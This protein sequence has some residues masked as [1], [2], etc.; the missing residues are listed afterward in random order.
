MPQLPQQEIAFLFQDKP[1]TREEIKDLIQNDPQY[2]KYSLMEWVALAKENMKKLGDI[3]ITNLESSERQEFMTSLS[4]L[5]FAEDLSTTLYAADGVTSLMTPFI[6][7]FNESQ[8][9][10]LLAAIEAI[11][12]N[13]EKFVEK[14]KERNHIKFKQ[15]VLAIKPIADYFSQFTFDMRNHHSGKYELTLQKNVKL[16]NGKDIFANKTANEETAQIFLF[17]FFENFDKALKLAKLDEN[18]KVINRTQVIKNIFVS[19]L[20]VGCHL[21]NHNSAALNHETML[22]QE[23]TDEHC[24]SYKKG[25][26]NKYI[27]SEITTNGKLIF[28]NSAFS[29]AKEDLKHTVRKHLYDKNMDNSINYLEGQKNFTQALAELFNVGYV[30][31]GNHG[32]SIIPIKDGFNITY[33]DSKQQSLIDLSLNL[34]GV[35]VLDWDTAVKLAGGVE[36]LQEKLANTKHKVIDTPAGTYQ[37]KANTEITEEDSWKRSDDVSFAKLTLKKTKKTT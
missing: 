10:S 26:S 31:A 17:T 12:E 35:S 34:W 22:I 7:S 13:L 3:D 36:E 28:L 5:K 19:E 9:P 1:Y 32:A 4:F 8:N 21:C 14:Q 11:D 33:S 25:K 37:L 2:N 30:I 6:K 20:F 16:F 23:L 24:T 29:I 27:T 18:G 15:M